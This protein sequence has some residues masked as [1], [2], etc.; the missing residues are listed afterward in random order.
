MFSVIKLHLKKC[1]SNLN[2][3][4]SR[5]TPSFSEAAR[6]QWES[7]TPD[8]VA[9]L[10]TTLRPRPSLLRKVTTYIPQHRLNQISHNT[11][12]FLKNLTFQNLLHFLYLYWWDDVLANKVDVYAFYYF[13]VDIN[14]WKKSGIQTHC[15][16]FISIVAVGKLYYLCETFISEKPIIVKHYLPGH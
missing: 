11:K 16:S 9:A 13:T 4:E 6:G 14:L 10:T 15:I 5:A 7:I 3:E 2:C 1:A 12:L 8:G